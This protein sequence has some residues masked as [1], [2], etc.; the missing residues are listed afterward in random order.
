[1]VFHHA[2]VFILTSTAIFAVL[3][4]LT[5]AKNMVFLTVFIRRYRYTITGSLTMPIPDLRHCEDLETLARVAVA[6]VRLLWKPDRCYSLSLALV[7]LTVHT[8]CFLEG[9][10]I[11]V[12]CS[13]GRIFKVI[14]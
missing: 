10:E 5:T 7:G 8:F 11:L 13:L 2:V 1:M 4:Q 6:P 9:V 14:R 12:F 3:V